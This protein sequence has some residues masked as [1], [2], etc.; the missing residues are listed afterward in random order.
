MFEINYW[1]VLVIVILQ[2]MLGAGYYGALGKPW[3]GAVGLTDE[4][5]NAKDPLPYIISMI[6]SA[7]SSIALAVFIRLAG[8]DTVV[9]GLLAGLGLGLALTVSVLAR[10]YAFAGSIFREKYKVLAFD[11][12]NDLIGFA[13]AGVIL[14]L[15]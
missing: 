2:A 6:A 12:G 8:I 5:I 7:L 14:A 10:H 9:G 4:M 1:A 13:A 11:A 15:W 3:M